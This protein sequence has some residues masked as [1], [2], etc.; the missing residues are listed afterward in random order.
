MDDTRVRESRDRGV[1]GGATARARSAAVNHDNE[2]AAGGDLCERVVRV[3]RD[4]KQGPFGRG[5]FCD[6]IELVPLTGE[7]LHRNGHITR[8][9]CWRR[10]NQDGFLKVC[11]VT[12]ETTRL[13]FDNLLIARE[14][15]ILFYVRTPDDRL[16]GHLG[17]SSFDWVARTCEIDNVIRGEAGHSPGAMT[18]AVRLL[19]AWTRR[20]LGPIEIR[21][22]TFHDN[23]PALKLYHRAGFRPFAYRPLTYHREGDE[24]E[25]RFAA[26][27]GAQPSPCIDRFFVVMRHH[28]E[29]A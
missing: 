16:I 14:D 12:E 3:F 25:W 21:L 5:T 4:L 22:Q 24:V 23:L 17:L 8:L 6:G 2:S 15:R 11:N 28:P 26:E 7:C 1:L 20:T 18:D 19:I 13:W 27:E 29:A 9:S 10:D